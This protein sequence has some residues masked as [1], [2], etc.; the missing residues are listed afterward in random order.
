MHNELAALPGGCLTSAWF[1][2]CTLHG[3]MPETAQP[4]Q[5]HYT[6]SEHMIPNPCYWRLPWSLLGLLVMVAPACA[7]PALATEE[8]AT[9]ARAGDGDFPVIPNLPAQPTLIASTIPPSG[10]LNPYGV[11][12]VPK[13]FPGG[14]TIRQDDILVSNFNNS[15]NTQGT[16]STIVTI[17]PDGTQTVFFQGPAGLGLSTALGVTRSGFVIVG[18]VPS[19]DGSG[20]C[21]QVDGQQTGVGQGSLMILDKNGDVVRTIASEQ[22]L[23][24]PWDLTIRDRG[25]HAAVFVSNVLS[26]TVT[27]L[28]LELHGQRCDHEG[29]VE[30][31]GKTQIASGYLH[32]CDPAAF[33]IG[34]TGLALDEKRDILYVSSTGDN[35]IF[36][37][38]DASDR[39]GDA[40]TGKVFIA[41]DAHLRGPLGLARAPNGNLLSAQGDAINPDPAGIQ[42]SEIVEYDRRGNFVAQFSID[43]APGS[44]FGLAIRRFGDGFVLAAVDNGTNALHVWSVK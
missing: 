12:F 16:G 27:R 18:N 14:G 40:G 5:M 17:H 21:T 37:V 36:A 3:S 9:I 39:R 19:I 29:C 44:A 43:P 32:R 6:T 30:V 28:D 31:E 35:K 15:A 4:I 13:G 7:D 22:F 1:D 26:G 25:E 8:S 10:D 24:G 2:R 38:Q 20:V 34:P 33:V 41:D 42:V 11:A 23:N